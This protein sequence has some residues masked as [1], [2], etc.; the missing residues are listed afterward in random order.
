MEGLVAFMP[1]KKPTPSAIIA[2]I[3]INRALV[4]A[5]S[6][7]VFFSKAFVIYFTSFYDERLEAV[8]PILPI[9]PILPIFP[10]T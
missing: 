2:I 7:N 10:R 9:L 5:I 8:F 6:R 3:E 4:F 1:A